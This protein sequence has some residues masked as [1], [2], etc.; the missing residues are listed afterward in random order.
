[1]PQ[2][3]RTLPALIDV[4]QRA[5]VG[6]ATVSRVING[7]TNVSKK[8]L[9]AVQLAIQELGYH[10]SQAARSLKG[11]RTRTIGLIVPDVAD[12]FFSTAAA[13]IQEVARGHDTLVF[14]ASSNNQPTREHELVTS[15]IHRRVDGLILAPCDD[16]DTDLLKHTGFPVVCFDRPLPGNTAATVLSDNAAGARLATRHLVNLGYKRILCMGGDPRLFTSKRRVHG[17]KAVIQRSGLPF[18]AEL[19]VQDYASAE[20]AL[21]PHLYGRNRIDAIFSIKNA[22][23]VHAYQILR[24]A[25]LRIP[26]DVALIGYDDF[27]LAD[28]LEPPISVVRQPVDRIAVCAAEK[29][30]AAL[31][32]GKS[33]TAQTV[34]P[35]ELVTRASCGESKRSVKPKSD[36]RE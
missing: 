26:E 13:A 35:V 1:M 30:F 8:T 33:S 11:A 22:V 12:S 10:P 25:G 4:A 32:S 19:S 28:V 18:L 6:A 31:T 20:A 16:A 5:G 36:S 2:K 21:E 3:A 29:L 7:G 15:F 24:R 27:L 9:A 17:F 14:L 23:T 34:L